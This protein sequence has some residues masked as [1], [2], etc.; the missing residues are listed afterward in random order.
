MARRLQHNA[1][2]GYFYGGIYASRLAEEFR[3]SPWPDDPILPTQYL[4]FEAMKRHKFIKATTT[5]YNY[6]LMFNKNPL[7]LL[8][9]LQMLSLITR[10][11]EDTTFMRA[12]R[13][14]T[15]RQSRLPDKLRKAHQ[16]PPWVI[17]LTIIHAANGDYQARPKS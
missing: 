7:Y 16:E 1:G 2:S 14:S 5:N 13:T 3:V 9:C 6:N 15:T 12:R 10:I 11:K 17:T 4:D 8:F